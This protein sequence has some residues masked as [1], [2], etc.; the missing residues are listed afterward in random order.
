MEYT[1]N[2]TW[3]L[4]SLDG[5]ES[6]SLIQ[7]GYKAEGRGGQKMSDAL[8]LALQQTMAFFPTSFFLCNVMLHRQRNLGP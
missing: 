7:P 2:G 1:N 6:L 3:K 5:A 4:T 8:M